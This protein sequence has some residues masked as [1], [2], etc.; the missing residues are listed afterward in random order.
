MVTDAP[1][2]VVQIAQRTARQEQGAVVYR[3]HR[4][5]DVH[6]GPMRRHDDLVLAVASQD[7]RAVKVRV[8]S[9]SIGGKT[10]SAQDVSKIEDQYEHPKPGDIFRRPFEPAYLNEYTYEPVDAQTYRFNSTIHDSAHGNG[11]FTVDGQ[12]N[13]VKYQYTPNV[14][15]PYSSSGGVSVQRSQVLPD[16]WFLTREDYEFRGHYAIFSG[17]ATAVVTYDSFKRYPDSASAIAALQ[18]ITP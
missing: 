1:P 14:F 8:L 2:A 16:Y 13:V 7:G 4:V 12:G 3:L 17:G 15:P 10:A 6:A 5:F 9:D 11:T 18:T